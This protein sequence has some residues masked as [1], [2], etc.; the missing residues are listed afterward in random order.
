METLFAWSFTETPSN[1]QDSAPQR[2]GA[3]IVAALTE[4]VVGNLYK[5][6][7]LMHQVCELHL[8]LVQFQCWVWL[9]S[10]TSCWT[11]LGW[12]RLS[13][14]SRAASLPPIWHRV[15]ARNLLA[16]FRLDAAVCLE[17]GDGCSGGMDL[18]LSSGHT[19]LLPHMTAC[20]S[21]VLALSGGM[22]SRWDCRYFQQPWR[23]ASL[24]WNNA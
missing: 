11:Q 5:T 3:V 12:Q 2:W 15:T 18:L 1:C 19:S 21:E 17:L 22:D 6:N 7:W 4:G 23:G 8:A 10:W 13:R 16:P 14:L 9:T 24:F 20:G